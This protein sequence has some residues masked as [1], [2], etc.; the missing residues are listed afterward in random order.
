[1]NKKYGFKLLLTAIAVSS[2]LLSCSNNKVNSKKAQAATNQ[3]T[4]TQDNN[5]ETYFTRKDGNLDQIL[6]KE[7]NA[8]QKNLNVA[9]YSLTKEDIGNSILHAKKMGV[10]VKVI[11]DKQEAGSKSQK[12]ILDK[13]K[14]NNIPVKINSHPGL[15]HLKVSIIDDKTVTGGSFNYTVNATKENDENL[16]I[17]RDSSIVKEYS[18]EFNTMWD[19]T[20]N[21]SNY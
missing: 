16:I 19:D 11:T 2:V 4:Q 18:T 5:I 13:F 10:D 21:Y 1:M 17:M 20:K 8:A 3:S 7:M 12:A 15:M 6:I 14:E 9:I